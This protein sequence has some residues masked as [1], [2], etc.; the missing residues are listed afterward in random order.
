MLVRKL[1]SFEEK[2]AKAH[3]W[4]YN[5]HIFLFTATVSFL[6]NMPTSLSTNFFQQKHFISW[7]QQMYLLYFFHFIFFP[8]CSWEE[9]GGGDLAPSFQQ[10]PGMSIYPRVILAYIHFFISKTQMSW[11]QQIIKKILQALEWYA[12][13]IKHLLQQKNGN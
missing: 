9:G 8:L 10:N 12:P 13:F 2:Q 5:L 11:I 4:T 6:L 1:K 7:F 3:K